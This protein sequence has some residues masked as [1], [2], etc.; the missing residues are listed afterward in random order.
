ML[1]NPTPLRRKSI[2]GAKDGL[3]DDALCNEGLIYSLFR[4]RQQHKNDKMIKEIKANN[5]HTHRYTHRQ[6]DIH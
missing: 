1:N 6:T 2:T 5:N 3:C 4:I